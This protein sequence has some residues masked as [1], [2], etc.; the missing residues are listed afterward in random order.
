MEV[1]FCAGLLLGSLMIMIISRWALRCRKRRHE[2][3]A[4]IRLNA[5]LAQAA[6]NHSKR[7]AE[8]RVSDYY[9]N[10]DPKE[11]L[12]WEKVWTDSFIEWTLAQRPRDLEW[13]RRHAPM[14]V[15]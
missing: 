5:R 9:V 1:Y 7:V 3:Q 8:R 2:R 6:I 11:K 4:I 12:F 15:D 10:A 14:T 13:D